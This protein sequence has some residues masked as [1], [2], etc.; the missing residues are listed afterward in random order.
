M[1]FLNANVGASASG[2]DVERSLLGSEAGRGGWVIPAVD[3]GVPEQLDE[4]PVE[5]G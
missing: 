5:R 3:G 4:V 1:R 2:S